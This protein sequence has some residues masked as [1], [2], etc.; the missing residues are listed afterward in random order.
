M[1]SAHDTY[2]YQDITVLIVF[3]PQMTIQ[4]FHSC[5]LERDKLVCYELEQIFKITDTL[6]DLL[7]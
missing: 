2:A 7:L 3:C 6:L 1:A 4:A 5:A